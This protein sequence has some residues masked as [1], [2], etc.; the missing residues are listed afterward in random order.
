VPFTLFADVA[1]ASGAFQF[2][3]LAALAA[4]FLFGFG[5]LAA[6][7]VHRKRA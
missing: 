1:P 3:M 6:L 4:P 5:V 7:Y 2:G